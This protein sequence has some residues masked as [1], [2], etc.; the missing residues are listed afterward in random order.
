MATE[1]E[2]LETFMDSMNTSPIEP[3][4][5]AIALA[6]GFLARATYKNAY[7]I[8]CLGLGNA[9]TQMGA[10]EVLAKAIATRRLED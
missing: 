8:K 9:S 3:E 7:Q 2:D 4:A 6:I 1:E 5:K 10:M